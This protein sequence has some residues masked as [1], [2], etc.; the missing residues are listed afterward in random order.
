M[1]KVLVSFEDTLLRRIDRRAAAFG[2]SRSG[3]L[4]TLAE[5]DLAEVEGQGGDP[6]A[7]RALGRLDRVLADTPAGDSTRLVREARD[8]R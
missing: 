4:A 6:V 5:R 8:A 2:V 1:G 3:Y 7:R